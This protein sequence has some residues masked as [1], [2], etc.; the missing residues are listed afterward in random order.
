MKTPQILLGTL[1]LTLCFLITSCNKEALTSLFKKQEEMETDEEKMSY[2]LGY[3]VT[4]NTN[5]KEP[6]LEGQFYVQGVKDALSGKDPQISKEEMQQISLK[7]MKKAMERQ[8]KQNPKPTKEET[9][10]Q[11]EF[12]ENN[13]KKAG[14][15]VTASG[16]QYEVIKEG[17]GKQPTSE[18]N[19]TVHYKGT[20]IDGKEF[21][22]SYKRNE[23][24]SFPL[25]GVIKGWTEGLQLMKEGAKYK[26]YIPSS[27]GYGETGAGAAIPPSATLIFEVELLEVK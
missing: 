1:L 16:L 27:L 19:V 21:D 25:N 23:P 26:F 14:V 3:V 9:M 2:L 20:L 4:K 11:T 13:K 6:D 10:K 7:A 24:A 17:T 8:K 15:K 22:S 5:Q 12:L 18:S